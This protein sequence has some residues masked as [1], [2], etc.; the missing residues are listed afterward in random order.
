MQFNSSVTRN[1]GAASFDGGRLD[2]M[3]HTALIAAA[4]VLGMTAAAQSWVDAGTLAASQL[5]AGHAG[6]TVARTTVLPA[7]SAA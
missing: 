2:T 6:C 7:R 5:A 3:L 1:T 4:I